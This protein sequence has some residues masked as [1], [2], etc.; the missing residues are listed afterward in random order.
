M[1]LGSKA[2]SHI[3]ELSDRA[4]SYSLNHGSA[5]VSEKIK[6]FDSHC[7]LRKMEMQAEMLLCPKSKDLKIAIC[8]AHP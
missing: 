7:L 5:T 1:L 2:V 4:G 8:P 3:S 6:L